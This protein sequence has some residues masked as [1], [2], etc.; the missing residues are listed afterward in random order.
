MNA[1]EQ[2]IGGGKGRNTVI[3][4]HSTGDPWHWLPFDGVSSRGAIVKSALPFLTAVVD[5]LPQG[6]DAVV[7]T[8]DLQGLELGSGGTGRLLGE[9]LSDELE[10]LSRSGSIPNLERVG[11][12]LAGG[13]FALGH[14]RGGFGDVR[15]VWT[16]LAARCA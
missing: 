15:P 5:C 10:V 1:G 12:I 2:P 14:K 8:S 4:V 6:V 11:V 9:V 3:T 7:C 13:L 16:G